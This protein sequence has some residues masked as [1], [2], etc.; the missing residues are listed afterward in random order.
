MNLGVKVL[1]AGDLGD[2]AYLHNSTLGFY[3][4]GK[5]VVPPP[6]MNNLTNNNGPGQ[7]WSSNYATQVQ[8]VEI[9]FPFSHIYLCPLFSTK[10]EFNA[11]VPS[12]TDYMY[13]NLWSLGPKMSMIVNGVAQ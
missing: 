11:S 4:I 10:L 3:T 5:H 8:T 7:W 2:K 13:L 6:Q 1:L 9:K 12:G